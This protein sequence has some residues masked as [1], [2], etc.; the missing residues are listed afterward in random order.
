M[1]ACTS[2]GFTS[3]VSPRRISFS[4]MRAWRPSMC[5]NDICLSLLCYSSLCGRGRAAA[6]PRPLSFERHAAVWQCVSVR[7]GRTAVRPYLSVSRASRCGVLACCCWSWTQCSASLPVLFAGGLLCCRQSPSVLCPLSLALRP[8]PLPH[9][10]LQR[11]R[12]QLLGFHGKLHRQLV[13][14][15]LGVSV[16]NH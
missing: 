7:R 2:P 9:A 14:H 12:Q 16:Y 3:S 8:S 6:R 13:Q 1:M 5:I 15:F 11:Y 10:A 4:S